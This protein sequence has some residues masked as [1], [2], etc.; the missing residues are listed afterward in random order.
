VTGSL[1]L[2]ASVILVAGLAIII[3]S[4][5]AVT[6]IILGYE[7]NPRPRRR[8]VV[9]VEREKDIAAALGVSWRAWA[10]LRLAVIALAIAIGFW[11]GVW[12]LIVLLT[13]L[14][15]A[16]V[17][18][19]VAGRAARR[20]LRM[21]RAFLGQLRV[22]RERMALAHQSLD[23]AL[24]EVAAAPG[25]ELE[26]VFAPLRR[27]G[28]VALN[29]IDC[30]DRSRSPLIESA[31]AVLLWARTR[32]IDAL[33]D[34]IDEVLLPIGEAQLAIEE[35]SLVTLTQQRAV[36]FAMAAL[37]T[38]ML[39]SLLRVDSFRAY[40]ETAQGTVVLLVAVALF[41]VLIASVNR[42]VWVSRWTRWD[43]HRMIGEEAGANG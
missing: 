4:G 41:C 17:R 28:S 21:E 22:L 42:I 15:A 10:T 26:I 23:T 36:S 19:A 35:E 43:L 11:S 12:L 3:G 20:R 6:A 8:R 30:A 40:Y 31:C 25:R 39:G 7:F 24:Q 32:S 27:G 5:C 14:A 33:I 9:L 13:A 18:F 29:L 1:P 34:A 37:M 2:P 38:L 16:G